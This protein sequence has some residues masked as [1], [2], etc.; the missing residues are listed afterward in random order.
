MQNQNPLEAEAFLNGEKQLN[1]EQFIKAIRSYLN[2]LLP[3]VDSSST[4][5]LPEENTTEQRRI[6]FV[7]QKLELVTFMVRKMMD[8]FKDKVARQRQIRDLI[9]SLH[10]EEEKNKVSDKKGKFEPASKER[11]EEFVDIWDQIIGLHEA[12]QDLLNAVITPLILPDLFEK[13]KTGIVPTKGILLYGPPGNGKTFLAKG[14]AG[15]AKKYGIAYFEISSS[16]I[17]S[18]FVGE[19]AQNVKKLFEAASKNKNGSIIFIDEIEALTTARGGENDL[20][21]DSKTEFLVQMEGKSSAGLIAPFIIGATNL[22]WVIDTAIQRRFEKKN[23]C[24]T[25]QSNR[26]F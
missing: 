5:T 14:L 15:I 18:K 3:Y 23:S 16:D 4:K 25:T 12:K 9:F 7:L 19:G 2:I 26:Y 13:L 17:L 8:N 21:A 22:P 6:I 11:L 1:N 20:T 24:R 10:T